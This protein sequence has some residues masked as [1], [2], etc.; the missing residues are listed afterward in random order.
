VACD[1]SEASI[2]D[3]LPSL[4]ESIARGAEALHRGGE[5]PPPESVSGRH[6]AER[7]EQGYG[8]AEVVEEYIEL[9]ACIFEHLERLGWVVE[10][11]QSRELNRAIDHALRES[12]R[13]FVRAHERMLRA[14]ERIAGKRTALRSV[15]EVLSDVL[16]AIQE[17]A[18]ANVDSIAILLLESDGRLHVRATIGLEEDKE[19]GLS[20]AVGEGFAGCIAE[21]G[22]PLLI[23]D[24][25]NDPAVVSPTLRAR[26]TKALYGVP[27]RDAGRTIGVAHI[28]SRNASHFAE[29]DLM[30]F[31]ALAE[32]ATN[33]IVRAQFVE[34][35][36]RT[37][38]FREQFIGVLGHDLR[39]PLNAISGTVQTL[40]AV[41]ELSD[42][43]VR[44]ALPRIARCADRMERLISDILDF[45]RAKLGGGFSLRP[46]SFSLLKLARD[47][48]DE[49]TPSLS[50]R[51]VEIVGE[52]PVEGM[53]DRERMA[54][55]L[56]NLVGNAVQHSPDGSH[57]CVRVAGDADLGTVE[58]FNEGPPIPEVTQLF[59]PFRRGSEGG[60]G[61][62]LGLYIAREIV[63]SHRGTLSL[64]S[65]ARGT[66]FVMCLPR[67]VEGSEHGE[68]V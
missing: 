47:V 64:R 17:S 9:R 2:I 37:A 30:L 48:V 56:S 31:R 8:L 55:V 58:V 27:L 65:E 45:T 10:P 4:L 61:L 62:G 38:R 24:A 32:H 18:G 54:Q 49:H 14:M 44:R 13:R 20:F 29:D 57:I 16:H 53:W 23:R 60:R 42:D 66:T 22:H 67:V 1:Q 11:G 21:S 43:R 34:T 46:S 25:A 39:S 5:V 6:A 41:R 19:A 59:E 12:A 3:E 35:L 51:Q 63:R 28:G 68:A 52:D 36:E 50:R 7:M 15:D 26:G 40:L 33:V